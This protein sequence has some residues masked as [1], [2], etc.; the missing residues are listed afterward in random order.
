MEKTKDK[1]QKDNCCP[2]NK[3]TM[4]NPTIQ[5]QQKTMD[6]QQKTTIDYL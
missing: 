4:D 6:K 2:P 5:K 1:Q 3:T